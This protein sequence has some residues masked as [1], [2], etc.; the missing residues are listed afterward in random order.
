[1][2]GDPD[3]PED[4]A[5]MRSYSPI[6]HVENIVAPV[7]LAHGINDRVVD[8]ADTERMARRLAELGKVHEVHYYER[9]G[10]GWHRWQTR[11]RFFRSLEEFLATH[12]GGRSGGF[13]YVEIG[14]RYL[15]P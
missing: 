12:L 13:D 1:M 14:A 15:F 5:E 11:V 9:E 2:I 7:F 4:R 6:N 3:N 10:H 8:R